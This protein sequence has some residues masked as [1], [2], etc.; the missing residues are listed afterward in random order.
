MSSLDPS[1]PA[2]TSL[3]R[4]RSAPERI[5]SIEG[6]AQDHCYT[7]CRLDVRGAARLAGEPRLGGV[8]R[9][10]S[11]MACPPPGPPPGALAGDEGRRGSAWRRRGATGLL[12]C[13]ACYQ[14]DCLS[15]RYAQGMSDTV[16]LAPA[17][18]DPSSVTS[19]AAPRRTGATAP[20]RRGAG[21]NRAA[22]PPRRPVV[23]S[24]RCCCRR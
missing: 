15:R 5:L 6:P 18:C 21:G 20:R 3:A 8:G 1:S 4:R 7:S 12:L 16:G 24:S 13:D 11:G 23:A 2:F 10:P 9:V 14:A 22:P 17:R 19:R